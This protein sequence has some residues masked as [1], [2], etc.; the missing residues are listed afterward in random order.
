MRL[1]QGGHAEALELLYKR[2]GGAVF[3]LAYRIVGDFATAEE[4]VQDAFLML[5]RKSVRYEPDRG[6]VRSWVLGIANNCAIDTLRRKLRFERGQVAG[7]DTYARQPGDDFTETEV[8]RRDLARATWAK[9]EVL[10]SEQQEVIKLAF[11]G[12]LTNNEIART[13]ELP[14]GTV[15]GRMRL[16]L[17]RLRGSFDR[18]APL[19]ELA[20]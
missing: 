15:K 17:E 12:E 8:V 19:E 16:G 14:V 5:W 10:P 1:L 13:L 20:A 18:R 6:S 2:H 4:V 7:E 9:L 3:G 11:L